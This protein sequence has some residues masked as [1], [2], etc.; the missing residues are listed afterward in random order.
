MSSLAAQSSFAHHCTGRFLNYFGMCLFL[1][2][3]SSLWEVSL[4]KKE[5]L[6]ASN[7]KTK[8]GKAVH[9]KEKPAHKK[10]THRTRRRTKRRYLSVRKVRK[11]HR[12]QIVLDLHADTIYQL[13]K[14]WYSL[15]KWS[16]GD[17]DIPK[18][19]K[20]GISAQVFVLWVP[21]RA[22]R[23]RGGMW[24]Y[25]LRMYKRYQR[26]LRDSRG[27][28]VH[29]S[30]AAE[31]RK[32]HRQ[33]K[34]AALLAIEGLHPLE[35]KLKRLRTI[36]RWGLIYAGLTWNNS[37]AFATS[38]S[39]ERRL[40]KHKKGLTTKGRKLI[41]LL[42]KYKILV[43]VSHAGRRTF[44]DVAKM[45]RRPFIASHSNVYRLRPH[46]RNLTDRQIKA[47]A[48]SGGVIGLNFYTVFL[49][50]GRKHRRTRISRVIQH[51]EYM[52]KLVGDKYI[53]LGSDF[54]GMHAKPIG[55]RHAGQLP[56]FTRALLRR[57]Y[58]KKRIRKILGENIMRILP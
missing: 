42:E 53:A 31:I 20:G 44:W 19:R 9:S 55:L 26:V 43:D 21:P 22:A 29:A 37:N 10:R 41:R 16:K 4:L 46:Y 50:R 48:K 11:F 36:A 30:T 32:I 23:M 24:G 1:F 54:D 7:Q 40:P 56:N 49:T 25:L 47:I 3:G 28:L 14:G 27:R 58:S 5:T 51:L 17:V 52:V 45:A 57:G 15:R 34:I 38:A 18:L 6:A 39:A 8:K 33:G 12:K 13:M 2:F 35:G